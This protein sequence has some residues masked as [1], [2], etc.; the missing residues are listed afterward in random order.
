MSAHNT[1]IIVHG[2][3]ELILC[4]S[5]ASRYRLVAEYYSNDN[6]EQSIQIT[7]L[8]T[9]MRTGIFESPRTL[10]KRFPSLK[11]PGNKTDKLKIFIIM[12]IDGSAQEKS[13]ISKDLFKDCPFYNNIIPIFNKDNLDDVLKGLGYKID[14]NN[15][16]NSYHD[17][18]KGLD[19][20]ELV[21][22]LIGC[23]DTNLEKFICF[24]LG[25]DPSHQSKMPCR[26]R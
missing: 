9:M 8:E 11:E 17:F 10:Y 7:H 25:K 12:D 16:T 3:S 14:I 4:R 24:V 19:V 23:N 18:C 6:G 26:K 5:I 20:D 15:K 2:K 21:K 1:L 13:Y 22:K